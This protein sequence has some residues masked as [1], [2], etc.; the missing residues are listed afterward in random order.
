[1]ILPA[2]PGAPGP[3]FHPIRR[4]TMNNANLK[5]GITYDRA[6]ESR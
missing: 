5:P 4:M 2:K 6:G 1:M 3:S